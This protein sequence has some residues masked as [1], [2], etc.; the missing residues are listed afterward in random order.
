MSFK[1]VVFAFKH[2]CAQVACET[3]RLCID[4]PC[5]HRCPTIYSG[6]C[7]WKVTI[8]TFVDGNQRGIRQVQQGVHADVR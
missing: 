7:L 2:G 4:A 3:R 8:S 5:V 1:V 6:I